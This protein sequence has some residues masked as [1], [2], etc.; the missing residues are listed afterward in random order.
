M[1]ISNVNSIK[2]ILSNR[3]P[4]GKGAIRE[5]RDQ[6]CQSKSGQQRRAM[7]G[8]PTTN[9]V[10]CSSAIYRTFRNY[11]VKFLN[12]IWSK[13]VFQILLRHTACAY[14]F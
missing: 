5:G 7:N 12:F 14:Y 13:S 4:P 9:G 8:F 10:V 1:R 2:P 11:P 6:M 3:P